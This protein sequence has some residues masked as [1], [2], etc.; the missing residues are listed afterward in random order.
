MALRAFRRLGGLL[1]CKE[2]SRLISR[3]QDNPLPFGRRMLLRLHLA[4][5]TACTR[6][7]QQTAFLREAMRRYRM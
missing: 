7:S 3:E 6:F 4:F 1:D 5:C 2:A